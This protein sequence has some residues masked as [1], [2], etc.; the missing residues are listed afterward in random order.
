MSS[1][2]VG[3][4]LLLIVLGVLG[5]LAASVRSIVSGNITT[6]QLV[7]ILSPLALLLLF[8]LFFGDITSTIIVLGLFYLIVSL[9]LMVY[10]GIRKILNV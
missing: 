3:L 6:Y 5:I 4:V 8:Y 7:F 2:I 10:S 1:F 9:V